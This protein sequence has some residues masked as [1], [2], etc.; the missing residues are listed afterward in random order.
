MIMPI[1]GNVAQLANQVKH[2]LQALEHKLQSG[3]MGDV[4][5]LLSEEKGKQ[6]DTKAYLFNLFK[7]MIAFL[8]ELT[9]WVQARHYQGD[10]QGLQALYI[11]LK[12]YSDEVLNYIVEQQELSEEQQNSLTPKPDFM[13]Q[14][15]KELDED[16]QEKLAEELALQKEQQG[17]STGVLLVHLM[18]LRLNTISLFSKLQKM[19]ANPAISNNQILNSPV[20]AEFVG[21][22]N[23][24]ND[25]IPF[26]IQLP[27]EHQQP[28]SQSRVAFTPMLQPKPSPNNAHQKP[29]VEQQ[30]E[31]SELL[32]K[33][34]RPKPPWEQS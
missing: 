34:M 10:E 12:S 4:V 19:L 16:E 33:M 5:D 25:L 15:Y 3:D 23:S 30:N 18:T 22:T 20:F 14:L 26:A 28:V 31:I 7:Q 17:D 2:S 13:A 9:A 29:E 11:A 21:L 6:Y 32:K 1:S 24:Y 8:T 27:D